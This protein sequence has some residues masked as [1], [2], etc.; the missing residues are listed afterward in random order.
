MNYYALGDKLS[1]TDP[2]SN[3]VL[4]SGL[5]FR[6]DGGNMLRPG[7]YPVACLGSYIH[8]YLHHI[9]FRSPVGTAIAY[10]YHRG[11]QRAVDHLSLGKASDFDDLHVLDDIARVEAILHIM[12][13]LAEGIALFGEFD[14]YPGESKS[15]STVFL[16]TAVTFA[17]I[18]PD[19]EKLK[20]D[21]LLRGVLIRGRSLRA[22]QRRKENVL[23]QGFTTRNG[24]YLPGYFLV[25]NLQFALLRHLGCRKFI[26]SEFYLNFL[27]HWFYGDFE[28]VSALLDED[29]T[30]SPFTKE[31]VLEHDAINAISVTFQA[32]MGALFT[33]L[34]AEMVEKFDDLLAR[35]DIR[36]V[37]VPWW[38]IQIGMAQSRAKEIEQKLTDDSN[39]LIDYF[40][41]PGSQEQR[42]VRS[43][44]YDNMVRRNY[45]CLGSFVEDIEIH[46]NGRANF[47]RIVSDYPSAVMSLPNSQK[48]GPWRGKATFDVFQSGRSGRVFFA[49]YADEQL[50]TLNA[51]AD[52]FDEERP[53][54]ESINLS[55]KRCRDIKTLMRNII[56]EALDPESSS[57]V[58][59]EHYRDESERSTNAMYRNWCGSLMTVVGPEADLSEEPGMLLKLCGGDIKFLR[60]LAALGCIGRPLIDHDDLKRVCDANGLT[61]AQF[62]SRAEAVEKEHNLR[63]MYPLADS[64]ALT[65]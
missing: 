25:K 49:A 59:R 22:T 36:G 54:V 3:S 18:V 30:L 16:N 6:R 44:C 21:A 47:A 56:N 42:A 27:V 33:H 60:T 4:I 53:E 34:T 40:D 62:K 63:V 50:V 38:E 29:K 48:P 9:C 55:T 41:R 14:A 26:D 43:M 35:S 31:A 28:L 15:I 24:G 17:E 1:D 46:A 51:F 39:S 37:R 32:R 61:T 2:I 11:F 52:G 45:M 8:E 19:W 64:F 65:V 20:I 5:N 7:R 23:M 13:P 12:R 57:A 10:L 58:Y